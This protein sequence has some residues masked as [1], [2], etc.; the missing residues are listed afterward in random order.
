MNDANIINGIE[1]KD[2]NKIIGIDGTNIAKMGNTPVSFSQ[3]PTGLIVFLNNTNI[4]ENW[5]AFNSANDKMIIGAGDTYSIG[6]SGGLNSVWSSPGSLS[7]A[8]SHDDGGYSI[9]NAGGSQY[10]SISSHV[11]N[12]G[13]HLHTLG[14]IDYTL[15]KNELLLIKS[16]ID[17][18]E[19]PTN[20]CILSTNSQSGL[21]VILD[22]SSY[23]GAAN[24]IGTYAEVKS[25]ITISSAGSHRHGNPYNATN[26]GG[27]APG[28]HQYTG[29][30][31]NIIPGSNLSINPDLTRFLL[32]LWTNASN[33]FD[34]AQNMIAMWESLTPPD[35]WLLC[36][37]NNSTPD[38]RNCFINTVGSGSEGSSSVGTGNTNGSLNNITHS[39]S[40]SHMTQNVQ[41]SYYF[42][43]PHLSFA[44]SH[45]HNS[46]SLSQTTWLPPYYALSFIMKAA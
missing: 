36:N 10:A 6:D 41:S 19:F 1:T 44:W 17:Q 33:H 14:S 38:L 26:T 28:D 23:L 20:A 43:G 9:N 42:A 7:S 12:Q 39:R 24:S 8:G 16:Q 45:T 35:G 37:G 27:P 15:P 22:N 32:S 30:H 40:H 46:P 5:E 11:T 25:D 2:I 34:P 21:S 4:P 31:S 18:A 29:A 13:N 3:I